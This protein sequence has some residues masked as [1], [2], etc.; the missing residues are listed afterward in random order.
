MKSNANDFDQ[1]PKNSIDLRLAALGAGVAAVLSFGSFAN[2]P[3]PFGDVI[4]KTNKNPVMTMKID[5]K[6]KYCLEKTP[7]VE[8]R[9]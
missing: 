6:N 7:P 2:E 3:I 8:D 5:M 9:E 4:A 1:E